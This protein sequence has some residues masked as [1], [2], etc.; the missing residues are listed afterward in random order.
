MEI[1]ACFVSGN[2]DQTVGMQ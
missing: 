1:M 2:I